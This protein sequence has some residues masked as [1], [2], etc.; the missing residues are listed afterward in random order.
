MDVDWSHGAEHMWQRHGVTVEQAN[1]AVADVDALLFDPDPKSRSGTSARL[2]GYSASRGRVLVVI[3]VHRQDQATGWWAPTR[4]TPTAPTP[5]P[6]V[7]RTFMTNPAEAVRQ[8]A[9][10]AE[11]TAEAPMPS[12]AKPT[13]PNKSIPV[14]VRLAPDDVAA[15]EELATAMGVPTSTVIRGWI[16]QGLA[17]SR[18]TTVTAALDQ[19][20]ADIQRLRG[21]V[22]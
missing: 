18:D 9:M 11:N 22:S 20:T 7:R 1:E 6:T 17:T 5:P 2:L 13:R 12:N 8:A 21:L 14:A 15:I 16:Q 10:E 19:I 3:L 4:G